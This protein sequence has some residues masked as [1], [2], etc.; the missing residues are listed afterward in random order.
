VE[1]FG[2][3]I[4]RGSDDIQNYWG[5]ELRPASGNLEIRMHNVSE[6]IYY[7]LSSSAEEGDPLDQ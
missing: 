4:L 1:Y 6:T 5:F 3:L 7:L 2:K